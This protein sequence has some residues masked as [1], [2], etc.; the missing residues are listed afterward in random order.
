M[1]PLGS[2]A[3]LIAAVREDAQADVDAIERDAAEA[4]ARADFSPQMSAAVA[5]DTGAA[6]A[7]ARARARARLSQEDWEDTRAALA[8]RESW[9]AEAAALGRERLLNDRMDARSA[10]TRREALARL[11][12]EGI[13]RLPAGPIVIVVTEQDA[14][15]L[16]ETW[17]ARIGRGD[18]STLTIVR[19]AIGGGCLV[20]S[21]DGRAVFDN[22]YEA[23]I[24]RLQARW[25]SVL[26]DI[27]ERATTGVAPEGAAP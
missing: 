26:F 27:Y 20:Q 15:L 19:Q 8:C 10:E 14:A 7:A 25:R 17:R 21:A 11:A 9:M 23:R 16:D 13:A 2:V 22:T 5:P 6:I 18:P 3:A 24:E 1:K 4:I 12:A